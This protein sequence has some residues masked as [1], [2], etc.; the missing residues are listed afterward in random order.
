MKG[1]DKRIMSRSSLG[2]SGWYFMLSVVAKSGIAGTKGFK[3]FLKKI[4]PEKSRNE[5]LSGVYER[6]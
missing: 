3:L 5:L 4:W 1:F 6:V 2:K